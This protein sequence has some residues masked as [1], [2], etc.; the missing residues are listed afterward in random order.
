MKIAII[1]AGI[2]GISIAKMLSLNNDVTIFEKAE[3]AG[4]L[5]KCKRVNDCLFHKVGGH[6]FNSKNHAV[7]KWFWSFFDQEK[8]FVK[9]KRNAKILF[10]NDLIG[11]PIEDHLYSLN[12]EITSNIISELLEINKLPDCSPFDYDN[13]KDFL[14]RK[15]GE[16]LC[17]AYFIPYN[18]KLWSVDL[19]SVPMK[20]LDG[21]LPMPDISDIFSKNILREQ[22]KNMVHS[23]FYYPKINGSQFIIER[24]KA[25]LNIQYNR[26]INDIKFIQGDLAIGE[27]QFN[28]LIYCGDIRKLPDDIFAMLDRNGIN[29]NYIKNLKANG[30]SN[31]FC[32][33]NPT[34][35]SWL[36]IPENFTMAHRIIYT[37]NFSETNNR[38]SKRSTCVVEFSG[39]V[40]YEQMCKEIRL[41][42]GDLNPLDYNYEESSYIIH[43]SNTYNEIE[44]MKTVLSKKNIYLLGRFAEWEYYNMDKAI[45]SAM[46]LSDKLKKPIR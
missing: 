33:T 15:F 19:E 21:K 38:G 10:Q 46:M 18:S 8:E 14:L 1:G 16:T 6:V 31:L 12:K 30:T 40:S 41:L 13:F 7:H 42:P 22:E 39:K 20:W 4:G 3:E 29:I 43:D 27:Y 2:S 5:I 32:E 36:Y 37:G 35:I 25:N 26:E 24:L 17:N 44:K 34:D 9:A 11:Y 28:S 45:E 23:S